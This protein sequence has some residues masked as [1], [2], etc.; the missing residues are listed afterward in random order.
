VSGLPKAGRASAT[1]RSV[2]RQATAT[3]QLK[4]ANTFAWDLRNGEL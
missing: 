1:T 4:A 2:E 3:P